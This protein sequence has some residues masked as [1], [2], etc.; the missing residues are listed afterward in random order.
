MWSAFFSI[1]HEPSGRGRNGELLVAVGEI[2]LVVLEA[3]MLLLHRLA[4]RGERAI[5]ADDGVAARGHFDVVSV[6]SR[7]RECR[8]QIDIGAA[9][10]EMHAHVRITLRGFD[11]GG[12][13]RGAP[14]RVDVLV[15]VAIVRGEMRGSPDLS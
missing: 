7:L 1:R 11:H 4:H 2:T 5:D 14:D 12:V 8:I 13:E 15:R 10:I 9:M 3:S 6:L